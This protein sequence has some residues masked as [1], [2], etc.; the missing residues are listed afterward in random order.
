MHQKHLQLQA[1]LKEMARL[2]K[3]MIISTA[4]AG[5]AVGGIGSYEGLQFIFR[6]SHLHTA[7]TVSLTAAAGLQLCLLRHWAAQ[8]LGSCQALLQRLRCWAVTA[9][10]GWAVATTASQGQHELCRAALQLLQVAQPPAQRSLPCIH[11]PMEEASR[12]FDEW[13][14]R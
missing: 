1:G 5:A 9:A 6:C 7:A 4:V 11:V 14:A 8:R 12:A 3:R 10:A 2:D 13:L